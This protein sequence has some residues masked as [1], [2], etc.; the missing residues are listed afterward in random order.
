MRKNNFQTLYLFTQV[1]N[2][3]GYYGFSKQYA[4]SRRRNL[5]KPTEKIIIKTQFNYRNY[6]EIP[7]ET[8]YG[9]TLGF[10]SKKTNELSA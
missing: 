2:I 5:S 8:S 9:D 10:D 6:L 4:C 1:S 7:N 3:Y